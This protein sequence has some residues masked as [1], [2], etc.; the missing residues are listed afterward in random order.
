MEMCLAVCVCVCVCVCG[1][2]G[3]TAEDIPLTFR[4]HLRRGD[5]R[6]A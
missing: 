3:G 1:G 2:G 6:A 4:A 5:A